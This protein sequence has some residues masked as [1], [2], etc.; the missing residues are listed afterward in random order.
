MRNVLKFEL[1]RAFRNRRMLAALLIG[2][3]VSLWHL[4][5]YI[6]PVRYYVGE[7][8]YWFPVWQGTGFVGSMP[9]IPALRCGSA[10]FMTRF[11]RETI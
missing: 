4:W 9:G 2:C 11:R 3:A 10:C 5:D 8:G 6:L 1:D 7:G